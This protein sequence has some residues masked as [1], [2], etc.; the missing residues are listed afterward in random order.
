LRGLPQRER[1]RTAGVGHWL[2]HVGGKP[3]RERRTT[4]GARR[5]WH[6]GEGGG[7]GTSETTGWRHGTEGRQGPGRSP[8]L[9]YTAQGGGRLRHLWAHCG[10][11]R[12]GIRWEAS[13]GIG[14]STRR[15][16]EVGFTP[17]VRD[18]TEPARR[19]RATLGLS[20]NKKRGQVVYSAVGQGAGSRG[21]I[22]QGRAPRGIGCGEGP[23]WWGPSAHRMIVTPP[24]SWDDEASRGWRVR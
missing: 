1:G 6:G 4:E 21:K 17:W 10:H 8:R 16:T 5:R 9:V 14:P 24:P 12:G 11:K 23:P 7:R 15:Q 18:E 2:G 19:K 20:I 22:C 13:N 3:H